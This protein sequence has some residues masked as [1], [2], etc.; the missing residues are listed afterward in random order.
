MQ[1]EVMASTSLQ[2]KELSDRLNDSLKFFKLTSKKVENKKKIKKVK[3][4]IT[5]CEVEEP[6][7]I[8]V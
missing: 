2:L 3:P 8:P 1:S 4:S 6:N 5:K 7:L